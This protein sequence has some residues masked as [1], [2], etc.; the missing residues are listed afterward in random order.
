MYPIIIQKF[1][2]YGNRDWQDKFEG[3]I[4][5]PGLKGDQAKTERKEQLLLIFP[6]CRKLDSRA[7]LTYYQFFT[8]KSTKS[9][10]FHISINDGLLPNLFFRYNPSS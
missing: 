1:S 8:R 3:E 10:I 2:H 7:Y 5:M 4:T 6:L 9:V